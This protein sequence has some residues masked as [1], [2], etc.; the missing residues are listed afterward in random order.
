MEE[1][2]LSG[3]S[4]GGDIEEADAETVVDD[5]AL[6]ELKEGDDVSHSRAREDG[7]MVFVQAI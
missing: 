5:E 1:V 6:G 7:D 2:G 3:G 4:F